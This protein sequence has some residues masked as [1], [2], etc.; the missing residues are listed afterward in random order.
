MANKYL[1]FLKTPP[2]EARKVNKSLQGPRMKGQHIRDLS[3][4]SISL[5]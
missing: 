3:G 1:A 2:V 5:L 4:P